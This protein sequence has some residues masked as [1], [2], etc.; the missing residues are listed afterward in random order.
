MQARLARAHRVLVDA[1][2]KPHG[3]EF[4]FP[5]GAR[6]VSLVVPTEH[7]FVGIHAQAIDLHQ[8]PAVSGLPYRICLSMNHPSLICPIPYRLFESQPALTNRIEDM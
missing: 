7:E 1:R 3:S 2:P 5:I 4:P 6:A 8:S